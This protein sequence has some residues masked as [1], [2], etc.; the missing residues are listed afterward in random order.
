MQF[1]V[2]LGIEK[3]TISGKLSK[4]SIAEDLLEQIL[5]VV[6]VLKEEG[7]RLFSALRGH[8]YLTTE[9]RNHLALQLLDVIH[10]K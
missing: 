9:G 3:R 10:L 8:L 1:F 7:D 4:E 6:V 2:F 5:E